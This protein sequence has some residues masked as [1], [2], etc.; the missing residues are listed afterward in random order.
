MSGDKI[1][2][3]DVLKHVRATVLIGLSTLPLAFTE[4]IVRE[5]ASKVERPIIFP[6]SNPTDRSEARP[7]DLL[8]WTEGRAL[9]ATG[10]PY[11]PVRFGERTIPISQ[12]NNVYIFP[13]VGLAVIASRPFA[14]SV[15]TRRI[16]DGMMLAAARALAEHSP[17]LK[18]SSAPLLPALRDIRNVA[19]EIAFAVAREAARSSLAPGSDSSSADSLR[20]RILASQWFPSYPTYLP[21]FG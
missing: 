2:L 8:R 10:S 7:E 15:G 5:M 3:S 11:A 20:S 18:D 12:C 6:L 14:D 1:G 17:A 16:T 4:P 13:A 19:V 21:A 9:V